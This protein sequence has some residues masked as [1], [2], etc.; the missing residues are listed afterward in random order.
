MSDFDRFLR[1]RDDGLIDEAP[2][3]LVMPSSESPWATVGERVWHAHKA[4][5]DALERQG[6]SLTAELPPSPAAL[7]CCT[8]DRV[9]TLGLI[10]GAWE[11]VAEGGWLAVSG[12]KTDG[13][14]ATLKKVRGALGDVEVISKSHGK[15]GVL[16]KTPGAPTPPAE[17]AEAARPSVRS[18][19]FQTQ[20]G[21]FSADKID[22]GSRVLA[23]QFGDAMK[24]AVADLGA[25]WGWLSAQAL[26][27]APRI[28][29]LSLYE[30]DS[31]A[32]DC[33]KRNVTDPRTAFHWADVT[34]L[35]TKDRAFDWVI[36]NPPFHTGRAG[37]P[38]LGQAFIA[39]AARILKPSGTA[40]IVANRHLPYE[41][42]LSE[43]FGVWDEIGGNGRFKVFRARK[44]KR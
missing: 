22:E 36:S 5:H 25:G 12:A 35:S 38:A 40:L 29:S 16:V 43:H 8:R 24:G 17:W 27:A 3:L 6:M 2:P 28:A 34:A 18:H 7:V 15:L 30:A 20:P 32:L 13:I 42:S 19:G 33:A 41:Q 10:A 11:S 44:T 21:I 37:T 4:E 31:R 1:A 14:D 23:E 26:A 9:E 39:T